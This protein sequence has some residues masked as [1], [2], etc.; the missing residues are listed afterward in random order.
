[1]TKRFTMTVAALL[2]G[3]GIQAG[4]ADLGAGTTLPISEGK[5]RLSINAGYSSVNSKNYL[6]AGLGAGY[7]LFE[8]METSLDGQAWIGERPH[9]YELSPGLRYTLSGLGSYNPYLGGFYRRT[10]YDDR[11]GM[12]SAGARAGVSIPLGSHTYMSAG[13]VYEKSFQCNNAVYSNCSQIYPEASL[14]FSY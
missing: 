5:M 2:L 3:T 4:W 1:M 11:K 8:G 10:F 12:D 7:F 13:V 9:I 14:S 6:V